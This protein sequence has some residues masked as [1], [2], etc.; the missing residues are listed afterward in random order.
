MAHVSHVWRCQ[1]NLKVKLSSRNLV[2]ITLC[3][4]VLFLSLGQ[5]HSMGLYLIPV[6]SN[7]SWGRETFSFAIALQ[8]LI[9]GA[10]QPFA[11]MLADRIGARRVM[12]IGG[13]FYAAGLLLMPYS[14]TGL[15]FSITVGLLVGLGLSG[16]GFGIVYG[17]VGKALRPEQRPAGLGLVGAIGGVGQLLVLP[18][19]LT[20]ID[21][22]GW[23]TAVLLV[24]VV[25]AA[26]IPLAL[27]TAK[28]E[29]APLASD[30]MNM[31]QTLSNAFRDRDFWLLT[32]G[33]LACGF[34]LAFIGTHMPAYL[35]D[36]GLQPSVATT[37]LGLIALTNIVGTYLFGVWGGRW[38]R[39]TLTVWLY[40][41]RVLAILLFLWMPVTPVSVYLF[42]ALMGFLW[43]GT[44]PLTNGMIGQIFG[45]RYVSTLFG[46]VFLS[47]QIGSFL[48]VWLGGWMYD[49]YKSYTWVWILA[50]A[51]SLLSAVLHAPI[52]ER[53]PA[54]A[55][56]A[57]A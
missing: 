47:H 26:I 19:N 42:A 13:V 55:A 48:G 40:L 16:T 44:V 4:L 34:Q 23:T 38:Q 49:T 9:W 39:K 32:V 3:G 2:F 54:T 57:V 46:F 45:I 33:F 22:L 53:R 7:L 52:R 6:T 35:A 50:A 5:R 21:T 28:E 12:V 18:L 27:G 36:N 37:A 11:G 15:L 56:R 1:R 20:L 43:L 29:P 25:V 14:T 51:L 24:S 17:A 10:A 31:S 8:N 41:G 30:G